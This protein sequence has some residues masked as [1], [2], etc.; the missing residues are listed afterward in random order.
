[1]ECVET[2]NEIQNEKDF[3]RFKEHLIKSLDKDKNIN[4]YLLNFLKINFFIYRY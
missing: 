1:M 3:K 2:A 4:M